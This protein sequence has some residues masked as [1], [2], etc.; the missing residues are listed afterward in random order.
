MKALVTGGYFDQGGD[1][2]V[3]LIDLAKQFG[4]AVEV[5]GVGLVGL[6]VH[7]RL[8]REDAV[9]ADMHQPS[10][11]EPAELGEPV[12]K[13]GVAGDRLKQ[14]F[15]VGHLLD[16]A[17]AVDHDIRHRGG[18]GPHDGVVVV[19]IDAGQQPLREFVAEKPPRAIAAGGGHHLV[20]GALPKH[21]KHGITEHARGTEHKN[22][23]GGRNCRGKRG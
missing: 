14:V 23:H 15:D 7:P 17:H 22:P 5:R 8:A 9:G 1:G 20:L 2:V 21:A 4:A 16:D 19:D 12:R 10:P 11:A 6:G 3:W 13:E 18:E